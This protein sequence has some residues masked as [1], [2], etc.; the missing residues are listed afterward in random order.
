MAMF[1]DFIELFFP[2][3]CECCGN[4][5]YRNERTLCT[6]CRMRLPRTHF[7]LDSDNPVAATFWG[8]I[9]FQYATSFLYF[10]RAGRVQHMMHRFK[11]KGR[12]EI[13]LLLG[14]LFARELRRSEN[15]QNID[16]IVP[17]PL[18]WSKQKKRGFNQSEV[19]ARAMAPVLNAQLETEVLYRNSATET[20]TKKSRLLRAENVKGKFSLH[21]PE[22]IRGK[23]LLLID[24]IITTG[25]TIEACAQTLLTADQAKVSIA[26]LAFAGK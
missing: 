1:Q 22:K 24:D 13:G 15:F 4:L 8:R 23:H 20:Q 25:A 7:H 9:N 14:D 5:L 16:A 12:R 11:Y 26:S 18:H 6:R 21:H 2:V 19:I 17:V 3:V 10:S